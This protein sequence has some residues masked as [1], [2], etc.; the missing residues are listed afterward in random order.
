M[1]FLMKGQDI[2][3]EIDNNGHRLVSS[4]S[5]SINGIVYEISLYSNGLKVI[6]EPLTKIYDF[7]MQYDVIEVPEEDK[8]IFKIKES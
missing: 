6:Y 8:I 7:T 5:F 1:T 3:V 4:T 2:V